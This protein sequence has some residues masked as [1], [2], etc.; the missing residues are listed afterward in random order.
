LTLPLL[1]VQEESTTVARN[2]ANSAQPR[3]GYGT[4][5]GVQED[6]LKRE[7]RDEEKDVKAEK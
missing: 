6:L 2:V 3:E 5:A 1:F 4:V 7:E